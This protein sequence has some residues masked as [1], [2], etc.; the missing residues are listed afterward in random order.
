[1]LS[2]GGAV[3]LRNLATPLTLTTPDDDDSDVILLLVAELV[4]LVTAALLGD[5]WLAEGWLL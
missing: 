1:M 4:T 2:A 5:R 3:T